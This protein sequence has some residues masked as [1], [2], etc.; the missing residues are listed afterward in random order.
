V[1]GKPALTDDHQYA[2]VVSVKGM[3]Y[4]ISVVDGTVKWKR[5]IGS[6]A[7][8]SYPVVYKSLA[9]VSNS[10][11]HVLGIDLETGGIHW[12]ARLRTEVAWG[13]TQYKNL[14]ICVTEGGQV[15]VLESTTG[16]KL[17]V[18]SLHNKLGLNGYRMTSYQPAAFDGH[19]LVIATNNQGISCFEMDLEKY[20]TD[21]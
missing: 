16:E 3:V 17:A 12:V 19:Q 5:N 20:V 14:S 2:I 10:I 9:I 15:F 11:G 13:V 21:N 1:K 8:H 4:C 6:G 7:T 18:S